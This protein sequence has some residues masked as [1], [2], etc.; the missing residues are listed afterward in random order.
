MATKQ[1]ELE[2]LTL[3]TSSLARAADDEPVFVLRAQDI[4]API[5][6]NLWATLADL[7][8][9]GP[10]P[11]TLEARSLAALMHDWQRRRG[12]YKWPD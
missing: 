6:V 2:H 1:V 3:G 9:Q 8:P 10:C 7:G 4:L 11:K 5:L 12:R